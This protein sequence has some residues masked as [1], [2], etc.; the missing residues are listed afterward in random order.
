[1]WL[2]ILTAMLLGPFLPQPAQDA[3]APVNLVK[4]LAGLWRAAEDTTPRVTDVDVQVFGSG[5]HD[6]RNVTLT[7]QPSGEGTLTISTAVIGRTGRRYAPAVLE[8]TLEIGDPITTTFG[9]FAPTVTVVAAEERYLDAAHER[10]AKEG[11]RASITVSGPTATE[12]E[13]R[14][15]TRDGRGSF[16]TRMQRRR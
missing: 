5:A 7:I 1:M 9:K 15:D 4:Q 13:F 14:F 11:T 10:F 2:T 3:V 8:A 16:G 6:V 12:L